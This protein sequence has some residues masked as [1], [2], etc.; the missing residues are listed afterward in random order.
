MNESTFS[1]S[2]PYVWQVLHNSEIIA[3]IVNGSTVLFMEESIQDVE[4]SGNMIAMVCGAVSCLSQQKVRIQ[5][6]DVLTFVDLQHCR[7]Y[8]CGVHLAS[9]ASGHVQN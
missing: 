1:V 9:C 4:S 8:R 2:N 7:G 6:P 3:N 5:T